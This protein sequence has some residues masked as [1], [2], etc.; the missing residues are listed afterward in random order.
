MLFRDYYTLTKPGIIYGNLVTTTAGFLLA[1]KNS[2][3][4]VLLLQLLFGTAA[5]IGSGCVFN[6]I[7]DL[8]I[9]KAMARTKNRPLVRKSITTTSGFIF[10]LTL[11]LVGF[12]ILALYT[13]TLT[14]ITGIVG[15][16]FYI[17]VYSFWKR[18]SIFGTLVGSVSGATPPVAGYLAITNQVDTGAVLLFLILVFWQMAHFYAIA[19]Y[20]LDDYKA[21]GIPVWSIKKGIL[22]T[23]IQI[24]LYMIGFGLLISLLTF[25]GYTGYTFIAILILFTLAWLKLAIEGFTV[26]NDKNWARRVFLFSQIVIV[27]F[28]ILVSVDAFLP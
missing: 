24:L 27:V 13:N 4:P 17:G 10:A 5:I 15:F 22:S 23:K 11:G 28:S 19:I 26:N 12:L 9:D 25:F 1:A 7:I 14:L 18:R 3:D 2:V 16:A 21:A 20:R 8:D 6:N